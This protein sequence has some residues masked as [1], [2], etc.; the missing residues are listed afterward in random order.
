MKQQSMF[1]WIQSPRIGAQTALCSFEDCPPIPPAQWPMPG[2][3]TDALWSSLACLADLFQDGFQGQLTQACLH[4]SAHLLGLALPGARSPEQLPPCTMPGQS[5]CA[6]KGL[7]GVSEDTSAYCKAR[8]R[9]PDRLLFAVFKH[10][11]KAVARA[12]GD[13]GGSSSGRLLVMDG[14]TVTLPDSD[15][16]RAVYSYAPGQK[17]GCGFPLMFLLGLFDLRTGAALRVIKSTTRIFISEATGLV[18]NESEDELR[19]GNLPP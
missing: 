12:A 5:L 14:T 18:S 19:C 8:Q 4:A 10:L 17:P 13:F 6:A 16:N 1:S 3:I 7:A 15:A 9:L 2:S 11:T